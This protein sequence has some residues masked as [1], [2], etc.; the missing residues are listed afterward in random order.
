MGLRDPGMG[1][2]RFC[3]IL[4][5]GG[6]VSAANSMEMALGGV[7]HAQSTRVIPWKWTF[8][9]PEKGTI[10]RDHWIS[11]LFGRIK[12][13]ICMVNL[14][15]FPFNSALFGLVV[16]HWPLVSKVSSS[17]PNQPFCLGGDMRI[18]V[19]PKIGVPR[20]GWF[21]M[22]NPL[23]MDDSGVPLFWKHPYV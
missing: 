9:S 15:D 2:H 16:M 22:E 18:W 1:L 19:F 20:N 17:L 23:K 4:P 10:S 11:Y 7:W 5:S 12:Q 13:C 3:R 8:M 14:R 21:I 6:A